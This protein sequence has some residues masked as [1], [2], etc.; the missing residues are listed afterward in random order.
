MGNYNWQQAVLCGY[1][2]GSIL[3]ARVFG[4]LICGKEITEESRDKN[5]GTANAFLYGGFWCGF[6][7]LCADL[8]KG[9]LPVYLFFRSQPPDVLEHAFPGALVL[10]APVAGHIFPL[11]YRFR[12]GKGIAVT[13]GS[14]LGLFPEMYPAAV[15]AAVFLFFSLVLRITPHFYRTAAVYLSCALLLIL[16]PGEKAVQTGFLIIAVLVCWRLHTS[17]EEREKCKVRLLWKC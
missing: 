13:F 15:L 17:E 11:F 12:G 3:F 10:A 6:L 9:F 4:R 2:A 8:L 1:L 14:L 16:G 7:T 5:P